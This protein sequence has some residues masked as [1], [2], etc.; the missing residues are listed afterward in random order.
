MMNEAAAQNRSHGNMRNSQNKR[1]KLNI[2]IRGR[3]EHC[4]SKSPSTS[5]STPVRD[6]EGWCGF[7]GGC[8]GRGWWDEV[9]VFRGSWYWSFQNKPKEEPAF[10]NYNREII[11]IIMIV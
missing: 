3:D 8:L 6:R 7:P 11:D 10:Y 5:P 1:I 2:P 4:W 9:W